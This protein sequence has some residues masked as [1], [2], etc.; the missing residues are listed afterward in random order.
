MIL[1]AVLQWHR[2]CVT[3][4]IVIKGTLTSHRGLLWSIL[5]K[6]DCYI[7]L[8][9]HT[10]HSP[11]TGSD[12]PRYLQQVSHGVQ[13]PACQCTSGAAHN[14]WKFL[15][16]Y[17]NVHTMWSRWCVVELSLQSKSVG[18]TLRPIQNGRQ[19]ADN[20]SKWIFSN[21]NFWISNTISSKC[22]S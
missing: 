18:N 15:R 2:H 17:T 11:A 1:R 20:V 9:P 6:T 5:K 12:V 19:F 7:S 3:E 13:L 21:E 22:V 8:Q 14:Q 4:S 10:G 16:R